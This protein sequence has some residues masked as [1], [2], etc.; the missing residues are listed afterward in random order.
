MA[1]TPP[2]AAATLRE[3]LAMWRGRPLAD[4]ENEPFARDPIRELDEMWLEAVELR[5]DAD[6]ATGRHADLVRELSALAR[7]YPLRE[8]I[9]RQ[10]ML[11]LYRSGRQAEALEAYAELR[12]TL[13]EELG[14]E[15]S[16]ELR[17]LQEAML[18]QDPEL[19]LRRPGAVRV[20]PRRRRR[21]GLA[22]VVA[23][24]A[25]AAVGLFAL[26][27][28]E[29]TP[30]PPRADGLVVAVSPRSGEV[31]ARVPVGATPSAVAVGEGRVWVVNADDQTIS[32]IDPRSRASDTFAIGATPTDLA[33]G[34]GA[35]WVASGGVV[36][37]GQSAG[38]VAT[39]LARVDPGSRA[40]RATIRLPAAGTA[41]ASNA[42]S[43][44]IAVTAGAVWAI[45]PDERVRRV[46]PRTNRITATIAGVRARAIAADGGSVWTLA[47]DGTVT[48]IDERTNEVL[49]RGKVSA[50][51]V[52]SIA[53][54]RDGAWI[55]APADGT[56]WRAVPG[57]GD[58]LV[59]DTVRVPTGMTDI[60]YGA[61]ALWGVNPL[62]GTLTQVAP[63]R[64]LGRAHDSRRRLPARGRGGRG[65]RV[66]R[67]GARG[68]RG[69]GLAGHG[70]GHAAPGIVL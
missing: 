63:G 25:L 14:L 20:V 17:E 8:H 61:G 1:A 16:R 38:L 34:A 50:T 5:V 53:A 18:R 51:S 40:P 35:V 33:V 31:Q 24:A 27:G 22:L 3:A 2:A 66:G 13:V 28:S 15:P 70:R 29:E 46:D 4:L 21:L 19:D 49:A 41:V 10:L 67:D 36:P 60:A 30:E 68:G 23:L 45:G 62:R 69:S 11:A 57:R 37:R 58:R 56:V 48:R 26:L 55:S 39:A 47:G 6:L 44:H 65:G 12:R 43:D 9:R 32:R 59:M 7:R 54:G 42:V 64:R 52:A